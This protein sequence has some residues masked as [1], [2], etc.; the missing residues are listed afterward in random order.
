M[1]LRAGGVADVFHPRLCIL[2]RRARPCGRMLLVARR[3]V[4][5]RNG[6]PATVSRRR[7]RPATMTASPGRASDCRR[8][9]SFVSF[10]RSNRLPSVSTTSLPATVSGTRVNQSL[11]RARSNFNPERRARARSWSASKRSCPVHVLNFRRQSANHLVKY[12]RSVGYNLT[13]VRNSAS[14]RLTSRS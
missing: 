1:A 6:A 7:R 9:I 14:A 12:S 11:F 3:T 2:P 4:R 10:D 8:A 13:R 5:R